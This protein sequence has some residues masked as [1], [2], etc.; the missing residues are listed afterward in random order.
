[1]RY[2]ITASGIIFALMFVAHVARV[3]VEGTAILHEPIII[4]TS[5]ISLGM[6]V[7]ALVLLTK[8]SR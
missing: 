4:A 8:P 6:T 3:L 5:V 2:F 7:W 1:V